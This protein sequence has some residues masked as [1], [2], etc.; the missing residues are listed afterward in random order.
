MSALCPG[1]LLSPIGER[2]WRDILL[3]GA[4]TKAS[5]Q[6]SSRPG[7]V[8]LLRVDTLVKW[9]RPFVSS[10]RRLGGGRVRV[11]ARG[12]PTGYRMLWSF[13]TSSSIHMCMQPFFFW[14]RPITFI[15]SEFGE[16]CGQSRLNY[17]DEDDGYSILDFA[18]IFT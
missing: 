7:Q 9:L 10:G 18:L 1:Q 14:H 2:D 15:R 5:K 3:V 17:H 11:W 8:I 4:R 6:T 16:I 13:S 12:C